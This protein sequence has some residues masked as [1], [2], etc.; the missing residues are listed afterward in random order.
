MRG[1]SFVLSCEEKERTDGRRNILRAPPPSLASQSDLHSKKPPNGLSSPTPFSLARIDRIRKCGTCR[2]RRR[3]SERC[4][5]RWRRFR[6]PHNI[7]LRTQIRRRTTPSYSFHPKEES[8][9]LRPSPGRS[10]ASRFP[11]PSLMNRKVESDGGGGKTGHVF[12]A[13]AKEREM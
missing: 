7:R 6:F 13:R 10:F 8:A 3:R 4:F 2:T 1:A 9:T 12:A 11:L 5:A